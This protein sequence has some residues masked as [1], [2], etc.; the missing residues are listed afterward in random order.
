MQTKIIDLLNSFQ[1]KKTPIRVSVVEYFL[2]KPHALSQN[3]LEQNLPEPLDRITLYRTLRTF[4]DKGVLHKIIDNQGITKYAL[5]SEH[6]HH[7]HHKHNTDEHIHFHCS[8]CD[9]TFCLPIQA[10]LDMTFPIGFLPEKIN[11]SV[12]GVC[13]FCQ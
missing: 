10:N 11:V 3:D 8:K 7:A 13:K 9:Q 12:E 4:E 1:L 6:C 2:S 5:C